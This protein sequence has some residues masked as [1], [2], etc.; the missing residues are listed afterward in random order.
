LLVRWLAA[1]HIE[2]WWGRP[3]DLAAVDAKY[4]PRID[5]IERTEMFVIE[6]EGEPVGLIQRY[7][8]QDY[9]EWQNAVDL[10]AGAG[11]DY[12]V[13]E[14]GMTGRRLGSQA[15]R[16]FTALVFERYPEIDLVGAA[17]QQANI[18]SWKALENAG[19]ERHWAGMLE[20]DDPS[21]EGPAFVYVKHR[22]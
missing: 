17:P 10:P 2:R 4:G 16:E 22:T 19:Y 13:G 12:L 1:A 21:D 15:I 14:E 18:A 11:I 5:G 6:L 3:L 9:P 8:L 20:S 7:L